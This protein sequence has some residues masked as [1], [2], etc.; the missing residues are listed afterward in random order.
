[1]E[2]EEGGRGGYY[3]VPKLHRQMRDISRIFTALSL[4]LLSLSPS[5]SLSLLEDKR[6]TYIVEN[7][8]PVD[9]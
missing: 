6:G 7:V 1:V 4:S 2:G 3:L 9:S 8:M 5:L